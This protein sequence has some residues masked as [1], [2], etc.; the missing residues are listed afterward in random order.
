M[1]YGETESL[2]YGNVLVK[3]FDEDHRLVGVGLYFGR[4]NGKMYL[5]EEINSPE[6]QEE[7]KKSIAEACS[8]IHLYVKW[9]LLKQSNACEG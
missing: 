2:R 7:L 4:G 8:K 6:A 3:A 1:Y 5:Q 9:E